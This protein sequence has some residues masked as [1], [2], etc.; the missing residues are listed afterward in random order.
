MGGALGA[1]ADIVA[2]MASSVLKPITDSIGSALGGAVGG[3]VNNVS[4]V[5]G[6]AMKAFNPLQ[7][8]LG[9]FSP[10]SPISQMPF[11]FS[12]GGFGNP[13][14]FNNPGG[15]IFPFPGIG[16]GGNQTGG[17]S[18]TG[19]NESFSQLQNDLQSAVQSGDPMQMF[20]AQQKMNQ[21][22]EM[23]GMLSSMQ[24]AEHDLIT[25]ITQKIA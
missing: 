3:I 16:T 9:G 23:V 4:S 18:Q 17:G 20:Q 6:Q 7:S 22:Q 2:P 15:S 12:P 24:K 10:S 25:Q 13:G 8:L 14:I 21:Y 5:I 1:V 19:F 11:P